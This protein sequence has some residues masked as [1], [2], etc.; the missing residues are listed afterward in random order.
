M[1]ALKV[2]RCPA[3]LPIALR[4]RISHGL[5]STQELV[6][7]I[8]IMVYFGTTRSHVPCWIRGWGVT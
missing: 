4:I 1:L 5:I 3:E 8:R 6:C 2:A 7:H